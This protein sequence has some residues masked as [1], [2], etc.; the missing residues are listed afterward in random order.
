MK[1]FLISKNTITVVQFSVFIKNVS[2]GNLGV[3]GV[4]V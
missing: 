1:L 2:T 3:I 4:G